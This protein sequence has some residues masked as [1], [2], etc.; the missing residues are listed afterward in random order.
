MATQLDKK[1]Q[2]IATALTMDA[3]ADA[4]QNSVSTPDLMIK[5]IS[6]LKSETTDLLRIYRKEV[7]KSNADEALKGKLIHL[8]ER[9]FALQSQALSFALVGALSATQLKAIEQLSQSGLGDAK[10]AFDGL[11]LSIAKLR[12]Q[13]EGDVNLQ[14]FIS[15]VV[16]DAYIAF[17]AYP[18]VFRAIK[19][20]SLSDKDTSDEADYLVKRAEASREAIEQALCFNP[21][22]DSLDE[23]IAD[24]KQGAGW[25]KDFAVSLK[26]AKEEED[27]EGDEYGSQENT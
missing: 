5:R 24:V 8:I 23:L 16:A 21:A 15:P 9:V 27:E 11:L 2:L 18:E 14:D 22:M 7:K 3:Y 6:Y 10:L 26:E 25:Y 12:I 13:A 4:Y 19:G 1:E 20:T 17:R